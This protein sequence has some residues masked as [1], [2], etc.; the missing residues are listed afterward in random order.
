MHSF[1]GRDG[2]PPAELLAAGRAEVRGY[3]GEI[4]SGAGGPGQ[5]GRRAVAPS[6][7][8]R[9]TPCWPGGCWPP[10][11]C[12]TSCPPSRAWPGTGAAAVIHCPFCHGYEV[13]DQ[14][15][16]AAGDP[17]GGAACRPAV[18][19]AHRAP[20]GAAA[21][22]RRGR[23]RP[24]RGAARRRGGRPD[25]F[26]APG[27]RGRGSAGRA[28]AER[29]IA[30]RSRCGGGRAGLPAPGRAV[31]RTGAA[32]GTA[33]QRAG[34]GARGR[35]HRGHVRRRALRGRQRHRPEP[36][37]A[38]RRRGRQPGRRHGRLQPCRGG[39]ARRRPAVRAGRG[40]GPA[41]L[42]LPAVE[43]QSQRLA[44]RRG[45]RA[46][47]GPG[48]GRGRRR[49]WRRDL[50]GRAGLAGDRQRHLGPGARPDPGRGGPARPCGQ[51]PA[52]RRQR[53]PAVRPRRVRPGHGQLRLDPAHPRPARHATTCSA[54][55]PRAAP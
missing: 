13:R 6:S 18:P 2:T 38:L 11:A 4:L 20:H 14:R 37:G 54:P 27:G 10:P 51:L 7:S 3:G 29:R 36:P 26:G 30:D 22:R 15:A 25:G 8:P 32:A 34:R 40:L 16:G 48:A 35:R 24:G 46:G 41:L 17:P 44:G 5:P 52:G 1:L 49:G 19:P 21:G 12:S 45:G 33:R 47:A 50:A 23:R 43:R 9:A 31:R 39:P 55:S 28:G 42:R 53:P